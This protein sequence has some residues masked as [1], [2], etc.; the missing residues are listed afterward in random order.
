MLKRA[1]SMFGL[2]VVAL[3]GLALAFYGGLLAGNRPSSTSTMEPVTSPPSSGVVQPTPTLTLEP[4]DPP[5]PRLSPTPLD[6]SVRAA[7]VVV[8]QR[9]AELAMS[10]TG[11]VASIYVREGDAV[12]TG[13]LLLRLDQ[14]GYVAEVD[15]AEASLR[16][17]EAAAQRAAAELEHLPDDATPGQI[18]IAQ[19]DLRLAQA[20]IELAEAT[21]TGAQT[22][23]RQTELR[24]PI[25][26]TVASIAIS[27]G[28]LAFAGTTVITVA[29]MSSWLIETTDVSELEVVRIA[30]GDTVDLTFAALPN[31]VLS[32]RVDRIQVRGTGESGQVQFA[33]VIRP[34]EHLSRLRWNMSVQVRIEPSG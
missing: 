3:A 15:E 18:E 17:A 28:E 19:T 2:A 25:A 29:D 6:T 12:T 31:L 7:G 1:P 11:L 13:Q 9:S 21:L 16:R 4:T 26:G 30:V 10:V 27:P 32:G 33:V 5:T 14:S 34:D 24:S 22:A 23:L 20:D 8:P